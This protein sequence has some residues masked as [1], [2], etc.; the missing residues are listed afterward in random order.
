MTDDDSPVLNT[1]ENTDK[2]LK[3]LKPPWKPGQSGNPQG[4]PRGRRFYGEIVRE[5]LASQEIDVTLTTSGGK[6][7]RFQLKA[8]ES[9]SFLMAV[10]QLKRALEGDTHA[11]EQLL[12]R[13]EGKPLSRHEI[14]RAGDTFE[15]LEDYGE[16]S[17]VVLNPGEVLYRHTTPLIIIATDSHDPEVPNGR[18]QYVD[19]DGRPCEEPL[20]RA[21]LAMDDARREESP[22]PPLQTRN[23]RPVHEE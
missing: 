8:A 12:S 2:R 7:K 23:K 14:M 21:T 16:S 6:T 11:C 22:R 3:N 20:G 1:E 10:S 13:A 9:F 17:L 4:R 5:L 15:V 18:V 19:E